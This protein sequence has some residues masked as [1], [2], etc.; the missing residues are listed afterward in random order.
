NLAN[1]Q[2]T[3]DLNDAPFLIKEE[4][5]VRLRALSKTDSRLRRTS[6]DKHSRIARIKEAKVLA[7]VQEAVNKAYQE[8]KEEYEKCQGISSSS[9]STSG[10]VNPYNPAQFTFPK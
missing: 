3:V 2:R 5:L 9:S 7:Q 1:A 8:G 4:H 10:V 6:M